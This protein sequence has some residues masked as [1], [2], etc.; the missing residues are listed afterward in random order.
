MQNGSG[1]PHI[2]VFKVNWHVA[3]AKGTR[4][5][6]FGAQT[7]CIKMGMGVEH[8]YLFNNLLLTYW[9]TVTKYNLRF[10]KYYD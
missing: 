6:L 7:S 9:S 8:C 10:V 5:S 2:I 4:E 1:V 3:A